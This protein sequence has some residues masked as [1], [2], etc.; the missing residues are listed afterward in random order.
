MTAE[1]RRAL[2]VLFSPD[3]VV[4]V[5]AIT[6]DG[7]VRSGYFADH[8]LLAEKVEALDADTAIAGIY[9]TLNEIE[10]A[11]LARRKDTVVRTGKKDAT[12]A[13][14]DVVLRRW[15]PIDLDPIRVAG[16]SSTDAEKDSARDRA[17]AI[18][19]HLAS[20]GWPDPVHADSG[21]GA[22]LL[23]RIDLPADDNDLVH[24]CLQ[25][26][27]ARFD[28]PAVTVD[29]SV[30]NAA[31]IWK[32]YGTTVRKGSHTDERPWRKARLLWVPDEIETI[33]RELMEALAEKQEETRPTPPPSPPVSKGFDLAAWVARHADKLPCE[34]APVIRA[35][36]R[37]FYRLDPCPWGGG[38]HVDGA[39]LGQ[40][41]EGPV[42]ARC[43]HDSCGGPK[44]PNRWPELRRLA[45]G[46]EE[47]PV[48]AE[49]A[50]ESTL[51]TLSHFEQDNRLYLDVVDGRN[52]YF[53]AHLD[54]D[55]RIR[56]ASNVKDPNGGTIV[57]RQLDRHPDTGE[58]VAIVGLPKRDAV[59][60]A[61]LLEPSALYSMCDAHLRR[62]IDVPDS[63]AELA[64]YYLLFTWF[65]TKCT[66]SP[67]LRLLAD[68][69]KGKTRILRV[70]ADLCFYPI[71]AGGAS[72]QAGIMRFNERWHGTLRIDEADLAG[73]ADNPLIKYLNLGFEAA[74]YYILSNKHNPRKQEFFDPFGPK[75]IAMREPFGD[76]ATEGRV[77]SFSPHETR[78]RDIPV[79]LDDEYFAA[80]ERIRGHIARFVLHHWPSVDGRLVL[81]YASIPIEPRLKQMSRP[82]SLVLQLFPDG[83]TRFTAYLHARQ[84]ELRRQRAVSWEGVCFSLTLAL[85]NGDDHLM[86]DQ[87]FG[88]YYRLGEL[89]A[90]EARM[91][92]KLIDTK[93]TSVARALRS[94]GFVE[95]ET[96]IS[97]QDVA[98]VPE[99]QQGRIRAKKLS[100]K[101][102]VV[103]DAE[104]WAE[105]VRRY[106]FVEPEDTDEAERQTSLTGEFGEAELVCPSLLRGPRY[107]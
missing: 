86:D 17:T 19:Q 34:V 60:S 83:A 28:D 40:L 89:Q 100:V 15:L 68:T 106:S 9:V 81:D 25:A 84:Q 65:H 1:I 69:G 101:R 55:G 74:Q 23:Y 41:D 37:A 76:N 80:V 27:A 72:S 94:I 79:E 64:I 48:A 90:V 67:Y 47:E 16:I 59:E 73:G 43:F 75:L 107:Q 102:L 46:R 95:H 54:T 92:A 62:Y 93:P 10:P 35:G 24:R 70:I 14:R 66:T 33:P 96:S 31:R 11:L 77:I 82:L 91:V 20:L 3:Q 45:E 88:K 42:F 13:D 5:R 12:T 7:F 87:K 21:N 26:L 50:G 71:A 98:V 99:G 103:P 61:A 36:Y 104:T 29:T 63:F 52:R 44:G 51:R 22:H 32:L 4:E 58:V 38:A 6:R 39:Y 49:E 56:F 30:A 57:P 78:R 8:D 97:V 2:A 105:M 85:A 18:A 53:F